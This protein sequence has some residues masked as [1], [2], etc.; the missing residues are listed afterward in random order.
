MNWL[1]KIANDV[2]KLWNG[3]DIWSYNDYKTLMP[4]LEH[5]KDYQSIGHTSPNVSIWKI[6]SKF[7]FHESSD[8][9]AT[10]YKDRH[11]GLL[12]DPNESIH[13]QDSIAHGR[14]DTDSM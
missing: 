9:E 1:Q 11:H 4:R 2:D 14:V 10:P 3:D 13:E 8:L 6:D 12:D 5:D 7:Q